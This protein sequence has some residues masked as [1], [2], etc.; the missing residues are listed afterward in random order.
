MNATTLWVQAGTCYT[1]TVA[2][3]FL[4][5]IERWKSEKQAAKTF[6]LC[7]RFGRGSVL[8]VLIRDVVGLISGAIFD[9]RKRP[10]ML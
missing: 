2:L 5:E 9:R 1:A 7:W 4:R 3:A 6:Q 10:L 8:R